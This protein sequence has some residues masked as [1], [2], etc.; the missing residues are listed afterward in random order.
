[1]SASSFVFRQGLGLVNGF[2]LPL[3]QWEICSP[4]SPSS[5]TPNNPPVLSISLPK[6][7]WGFLFVF[8]FLNL[9]AFLHLSHCP[10]G[11]GLHHLILDKDRIFLMLVFPLRLSLPPSTCAK[12]NSLSELWVN[13]DHVTSPFKSAPWIPMVLPVKTKVSIMIWKSLV[14]HLCLSLQCT[15][16]KRMSLPLTPSSTQQHLVLVW[17][18]SSVSSFCLPDACTTFRPRAG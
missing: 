6:V 16:W 14:V 11:P 15:L 2:S 5:T 7:F 12:Q 9:S 4:P 10:S 8:L 13:A 1:M 17:S 3:I 18:G